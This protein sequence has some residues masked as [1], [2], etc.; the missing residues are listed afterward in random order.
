MKK[1]SK[2]FQ[3]VIFASL[4]FSGLFLAWKPIYA[5]ENLKSALKEAVKKAEEISEIKNNGSLSEKDREEKELAVRKEA[6]NTIFNLTILENNDLKNK[7]ESLKNLNEKQEKTRSFLLQSLK[8][9]ENSFEEMGNR[10]REAG[11]QEEVKQLA[12]DFKN[13]RNLAYNPKTEKIT[14]FNLVFQGKNI[15]AVANSRLNKI[16][17]DLN[18][19]NGADFEWVGSLL[20][21][22]ELKIKKSEDLNL[23]A[24]KLI[25]QEIN[26]DKSWF[27]FKKLFYKNQI[28]AVKLLMEESGQNIKDA[29]QIFIEL[30]KALKESNK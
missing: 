19:I 28:P 15:I 22:A 23:S 8:E 21:K 27:L 1:I 3:M 2:K 10:L 13:W 18:E 30:G 6:L 20:D 5:E 16:W 29:Y 17:E 7:L 4:M 11:T 9:N 26:K 25:I 12:A 24:E 14:A